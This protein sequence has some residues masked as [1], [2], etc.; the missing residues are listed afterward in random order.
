MDDVFSTRDTNSEIHLLF[1]IRVADYQPIVRLHLHNWTITNG[2]AFKVNQISPSHIAPSD[3]NLS[4]SIE[5]K[6]ADILVI[7]RNEYRFIRTGC[8]RMKSDHRSLT[9]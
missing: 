4:R 5:Q 1:I 2:T 9:G 8:E 6:M 3:R 7:I